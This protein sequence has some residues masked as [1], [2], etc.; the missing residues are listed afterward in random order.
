MPAIA[1]RARA[2]ASPRRPVSVPPAGVTCE[3]S[4]DLRRSKT[5]A[6]PRGP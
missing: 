4:S 1:R 5:R 6:L 2:A 3:V